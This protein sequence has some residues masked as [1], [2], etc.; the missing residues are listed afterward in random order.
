MNPA[1]PSTRAERSDW[2]RWT[3]LVASPVP[4]V[5]LLIRSYMFRSSSWLAGLARS[6]DLDRVAPAAEGV[7]YRDPVARRSHG[8]VEMEGRLRDRRRV[9]GGDKRR[10]GT[11]G[12]PPDGEPEAVD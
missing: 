3:R 6:V 5:S 1:A 8:V 4:M 2:M 10:L 11:R 7:D 9:G 12:E